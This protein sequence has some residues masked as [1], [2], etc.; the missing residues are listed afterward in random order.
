MTSINYEVPQIEF[1][2]IHTLH[3]LTINTS[4]NIRTLW[5]VIYD[6][7]TATRFGTEMPSSG[8]IYFCYN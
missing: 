7:S 3:A 4:S 6:I 1:Y 2:V 8:L 5:Y